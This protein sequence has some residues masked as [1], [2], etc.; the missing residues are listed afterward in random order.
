MNLQT[1]HNT[2]HWKDLKYRFQECLPY[3]HFFFQENDRRVDPSP[4]RISTTRMQLVSTHNFMQRRNDFMVQGG[5]L[6]SAGIAI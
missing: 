1:N 3:K 2:Q 5:A 6:G 4:S